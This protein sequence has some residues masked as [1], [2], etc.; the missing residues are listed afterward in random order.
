MERT[1]TARYDGNM[2]VTVEFFGIPRERAG[3]AEL[4][5][6]QAGTVS[7]LLDCVRR[8]CPQLHDLVK[9]NGR[10]ARHYLLSLDGREF[11]TN[12]S[13]ALPAGSRVLLLSADAGG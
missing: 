12:L 7:E 9:G 8:A 3:R 6:S 2:A 4:V 1:S 11:V 5:V 10:L 13:Q